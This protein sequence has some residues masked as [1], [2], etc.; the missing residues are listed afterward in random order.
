M[1]VP[2][3]FLDPVTS[4][5]TA[6]AAVVVVALA[7]RRSSAEHDAH[8]VPLAGLT[9]AFVFAAQMVNFP[10][11]LGTSGHLL[12]GTLVAVLVGPWT[13]ILVLA[14]VLTVQALLFA[15]GG[16]TALGTNIL[17]VGVVTV[18]VGWAITRLGLLVLPRRVSSVVPAAFVGA[19]VSVPVAAACFVL[20]YAVGGQVAL[21]MDALMVTMTG[22]HALI[23]LGEAFITAMVLAAVVAV[24]PDLVYAAR[25]LRPAL[26]LAP[27]A[28]SSHESGLGSGSGGSAS[29][30]QTDPAGD[31]AAEPSEDA[32]ADG[33]SGLWRFGAVTLAAC[34]VIA[35]GLGAVASGAPDGLEYVAETTGFASSADEHALAEQSFADYG[36]AGGIPLPVVAVVGI[37]LVLLISVAAARLAATRRVRTPVS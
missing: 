2:D 8:T 9:G 22:W 30:L 3:G 17:L 6:L 28:V 16:I 4:A 34:L 1:H 35:V 27:A 7:L 19:L 11:G 5:A 14:V 18:A 15:D 13:G 32:A 10:V 24:R 37:S 31:V 29:T 23:G 33:R 20:L 25:G 21:P 12:G 36:E 26:E